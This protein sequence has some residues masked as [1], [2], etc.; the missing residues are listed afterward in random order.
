MELEEIFKNRTRINLYADDEANH[1]SAGAIWNGDWRKGRLLRGWFGNDFK[2]RHYAVCMGRQTRCYD[3]VNVLFFLPMTS[4]PHEFGCYLLKIAAGKVDFL[5]RDTY[6][7]PICMLMKE[8]SL[9][10]W[11][12]ANYQGELPNELTAELKSAW[13]ARIRSFK[14][15]ENRK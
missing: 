15:K 4:M 14:M 9:E 8:E 11:A 6:V 1:Y 2:P 5:P 7:L 10:Y 3:Y 12:E 13:A